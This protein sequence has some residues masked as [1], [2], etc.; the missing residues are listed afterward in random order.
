MN[1]ERKFDIV[2]TCEDDNLYC[3][4]FQEGDKTLTWDDL[5]ETERVNVIN[6]FSAFL[7]MYL[8]EHR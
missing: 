6:R 7:R 2:L 1:N 3:C 8:M 5:T 4:K